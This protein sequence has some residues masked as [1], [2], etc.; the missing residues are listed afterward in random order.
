MDQSPLTP[1][2]IPII[3]GFSV[4]PASFHDTPSVQA[5]MAEKITVDDANSTIFRIS[6]RREQQ[7]PA[8]AFLI[9]ALVATVPGISTV[10]FAQGGVRE[11]LLFSSLPPSVRAE[12]PLKAATKEYAPPAYDSLWSL[13]KSAVPLRSCPPQIYSLFGP[14]IALLYAHCSL[15]KEAHAAAALHSTTTGILASV[16]GITHEER[17]MLALLLCERW[18][19]EVA[20][21]DQEFLERVQTLVGRELSWWCR[22][23]GRI[24]GLV[25]AVYPAGKV[26][27]ERLEVA[28]EATAKGVGLTLHWTEGKGEFEKEVRVVEKVGKKK[29]WIGGREGWGLKVEIIET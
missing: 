20:P 27:T 7:V 25:G 8:I 11:G 1:Y 14:F 6:E 19:G 29:H 2:P 12:N 24:G 22:Y 13:I 23:A 10:R 3:N 26:P 28:A 17:A 9:S 5:H 21:T 16:H 18:G 4:S 15:P